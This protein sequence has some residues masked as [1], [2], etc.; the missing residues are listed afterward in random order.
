MKSIAYFRKGIFSVLVVLLFQAT[1][2]K[3]V[4]TGEERDSQLQLYGQVWGFLRFFQSFCLF[5][6]GGLG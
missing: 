1:P 3:A 2:V 4:I 6:E 5:R